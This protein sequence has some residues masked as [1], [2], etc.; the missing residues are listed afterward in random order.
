MK[1]LVAPEA[2]PNEGCYRPLRVIVPEGSVLNADPDRPVVGGNHETPQRVGDAI[3]RAMAQVI[4][5][6]VQAGGPTTPGLRIRAAAAPPGGLG[7]H[8][9]GPAG[10]GGATAGQCGGPATAR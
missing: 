1:A 6:R 8:F 9:G 10:G 5:D 2:P 3:M 4:P 7:A